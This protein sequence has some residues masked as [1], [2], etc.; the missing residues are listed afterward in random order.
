MHALARTL[1]AIGAL[2]SS[3]SLAANPNADTRTLI[4]TAS[5]APFC[6]VRQASSEVQLNGGEASL[7]PV[8][9]VC[10]SAGG[11]RVLASFVNLDR[12]TIVTADGSAALGEDGTV[13]FVRPTARKLKQNWKVR[14]AVKRDPNAPVLVQVN[15]SPL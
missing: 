13:T 8:T 15:V 14:D 2:A 12:A 7:G 9:E 5:V 10:N 4:L 1:I 3:A 11:Y 6:Q